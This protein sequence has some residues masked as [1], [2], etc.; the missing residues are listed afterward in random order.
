[1]IRFARSALLPCL[2]LLIASAAPAAT[3]NFLLDG[4]AGL[5]LLGGNENP[6]V[7]GGGSGGIL[8]AISLDTATNQLTIG[9]G[10]GS[11]NGFTDLTGAAT[12]S[13]IHGGSGVGFSTNAGVLVNL[14][15]IL[16]TSAS[17][18]GLSGIV[19]LSDAQEALLLN[20]ETYI[21]VHTVANGPGEIRGHL[22]VPEPATA[23]LFGLGFVALAISRRSRP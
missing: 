20:G 23:L 1:M 4:N 5:G 17:S 16:D 19:T 18:G 21:N 15:G 7:G 2:G 12:A 22:V 3:I 8:S 14:S 10:W 6:P 11:G 13:H 9:I